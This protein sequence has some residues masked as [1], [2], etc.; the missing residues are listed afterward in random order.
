MTNKSARA[1]RASSLQVLWSLKNLQVLIYYKLPEK[2]HVIT[3]AS[4]NSIC[5]QL[6]PSPRAPLADLRALA[7]FFT[8]DGKF[9]EV[10]TLE[11]SNPLGWGQKKRANAPSSINSATFFIDRT[12]E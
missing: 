7:F 10:G 8:L 5:A 12:V 2:N 1:R 3:Y 11:L 4:V 9:P 6:P